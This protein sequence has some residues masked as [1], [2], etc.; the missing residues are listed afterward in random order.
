MRLFQIA[1][2]FEKY[3]LFQTHGNLIVDLQAKHAVSGGPFWP[4]LIIAFSTYKI[5]SVKCFHCSPT[6]AFD[7]NKNHFTIS[8]KNIIN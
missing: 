1:V 2:A 5:S 6:K 3:D 8:P 4:T 7:Q